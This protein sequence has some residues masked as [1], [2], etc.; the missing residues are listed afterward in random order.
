M[1]KKKPKMWVFSPPK[2]P[3]PKV[4]EELKAQVQEKAN[5]L[6]ET[7]LKP[8]Y[9]QPPPKDERFNYLVDIYTKWHRNYFYFC[10]IYRSPGPNAISPGF[11]SRFARLEYTGGNR[12]NLSYFRH[13]GQWWELYT[14]LTL[15]KALAAIRDE[16]HFMP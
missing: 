4:P 12:F 1:A 15:D 14:G 13:T 2:P 11:E 6:V 3:K 9:I 10:S 8:R 16:P 7:V 5:Q